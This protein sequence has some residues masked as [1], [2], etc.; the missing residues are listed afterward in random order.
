MD[1]LSRI[2]SSLCLRAPLF[3]IIDLSGDVSIRTPGVTG[4]TAFHFVSEGECRICEGDREHRLVK[5]EFGIFP[6]GPDF[7]IE[8]GHKVPSV[9]FL[10]LK[11]EQGQPSWSARQGPETPVVIRVG[12]APF[13]T[14]LLTGMFILDTAEAEL[15]TGVA[16]L[17]LKFGPGDARLQNWAMACLNLVML[18]SAQP[19]PGFIAIAER[20]LQLLLAQTLRDWVLHYQHTGLARGLVD[21]RIHRVLQAIHEHPARP[22]TLQELARIAGRSRSSFAVLFTEIMSETPIAYLTRW[23]M[24]LA[25]SHLKDS[26]EPISNIAESL[27]YGSFFAFSRTFRTYYQMTPGNYRRLAQFAEPPGERG[28]RVV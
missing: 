13:T 6:H 23:R 1:V 4:V 28:R 18:E 15:L 12:Q 8:T 11:A 24:Y 17:S 10:D 20:A 22:W 9:S 14:Q 19:Q 7:R 21:P 26:S 16:P 2:L 25:A 27:G 5:G 3:S